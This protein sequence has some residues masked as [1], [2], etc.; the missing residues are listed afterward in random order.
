VSDNGTDTNIQHENSCLIWQRVYQELRKISDVERFII[1][2]FAPG[3]SPSN[4]IERKFSGLSKA[5]VGL[6]DKDLDRALET[7]NR[8]WNE[9]EDTECWIEKNKK[10][11]TRIQQKLDIEHFQK[12]PYMIEFSANKTF[13]MVGG[14][15]RAGDGRKVSVGK[16]C[17]LC[18]E[19]GK[20]YFCWS[21]DAYKK[22]LQKYH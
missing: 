20:H 1:V 12:L 10:Q 2:S 3:D 8:L 22:H 5:L 7:I 16:F 21:N 17:E 9:L 15:E 13:T 19:A 14:A 18:A 6:G 11:I 4:M